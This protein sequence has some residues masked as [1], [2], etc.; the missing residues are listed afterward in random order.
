MNEITD[1]QT[2][3]LNRQLKFIYFELNTLMSMKSIFINGHMKM[4]KTSW[5]YGNYDIRQNSFID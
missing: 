1:K 5:K 3:L 2:E 4:D